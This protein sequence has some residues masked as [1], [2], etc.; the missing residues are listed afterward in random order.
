MYNLWKQKLQL[1][2][3]PLTFWFTKQTTNW[4]SFYCR[5][6]SFIKC[7][8]Q[9]ITFSIT[10]AKYDWNKIPE[11]WLI[12]SRRKRLMNLWNLDVESGFYLYLWRRNYY[13]LYRKSII[14][15]TKC[16]SISHAMKVLCCNPISWK[17]TLHNE[18]RYV[19]F[20]ILWYDFMIRIN[21]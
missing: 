10:K 12:G 1:S 16:F 2:T 14:I 4:Y 21:T 18:H 7:F 13:F 11:F 19:L 5:S 3:N 17:N 15:N 8:L 9:Y 6:E 20:L